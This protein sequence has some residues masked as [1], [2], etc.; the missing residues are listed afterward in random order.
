M[1]RDRIHVSAISLAGAPCREI[2]LRLAGV[3]DATDHLD[4]DQLDHLNQCVRCQAELVQYRK[5]L[6]A[7]RSLRREVDSIPP[8]LA[9]VVLEKLDEQHL[10]LET[11]TPNPRRAAYLGGLAAAATAAGAGAAI[12]L[13]NRGRKGAA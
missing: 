8:H 5:L 3:V 2:S 11:A 6:R 7:M 10:T 13:M 12:V 1:L 9:T 4:P